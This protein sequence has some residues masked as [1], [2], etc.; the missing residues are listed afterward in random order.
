VVS[1]ET[2]PHGNGSNPQAVLNRVALGQH[3]ADGLKRIP[4]MKSQDSH[5]F[6]FRSLM[7]L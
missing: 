4:V 1:R 3:S 5:G 7:R 6:V 2:S